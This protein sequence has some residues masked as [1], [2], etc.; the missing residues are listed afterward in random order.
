ME[1]HQELQLCIMVQEAKEASSSK[2]TGLP[3]QPTINGQKRYIR[4]LWIA[5]YAVFALLGESAATL[6]GRLY[7][8][9]GG[10][11][12]WMGTLLQVIGFPILLPYYCFSTPKTSNRDNSTLTR[13]PSLSILAFAY[14]SLGLLLALDCYLYSVGLM[15]LPVSTYSII[16][17]TQLAFNAFFAFFLNN[18]KFTPSIVN[19][20]VLLT[21][22]STL[23]VFQ[24]GSADS[25]EISK[26]KYVIGFISTLAASAGY[27]LLLSLTQFAFM[28]LQARETLKMVMDMTMYQSNVA[29]CA[30][31]V[32]LFSSGEWKGLKTEIEEFKLRKLFYVLILSFKAISWQVSSIGSVGL[33]FEVSSL[34]SNAI[35][36]LSLP[37]VPIMSVIF[38]HDRMHGIK[39]ISLVLAIWGFVSYIYQQYQQE[40]C[41][42][43]GDNTEEGQYMN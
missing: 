32:G 43:N 29:S 28:K 18:L 26:G 42:I 10:K 8:D 35:S 31:L 14:V 27:G 39:V 41:I 13:Q 37:I 19:S 40:D 6:L 9:K 33:I 36:V 2:N 11:S 12:K 4:W 22:S 5:L 30:T 3:N 21:I 24:T 15:Y 20:L 34:F 23:L 7:Y 16:S 17:S 1:E 25:G 38:F